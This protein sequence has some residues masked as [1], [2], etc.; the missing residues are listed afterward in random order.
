MSPTS[1]HSRKMLPCLTTVGWTKRRCE[2][3]SS[4]TAR[5][6]GT[7]SA[8]QGRRLASQRGWWRE[9]VLARP[10]GGSGQR[11][12]QAVHGGSNVAGARHQVHLPAARPSATVELP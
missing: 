12:E 5:R 1:V 7:P 9:L 8:S 3:G 6:F 11:P 4:A 10:G 2:Y